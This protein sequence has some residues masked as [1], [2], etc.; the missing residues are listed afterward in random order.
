VWRPARKREMEGEGRSG[1]L[2]AM[3]QQSGVRSFHN[4]RRNLSGPGEE[5]AKVG[6]GKSAKKTAEEAEMADEAE[7]YAKYT[8]DWKSASSS[9]RR[10]FHDESEKQTLMFI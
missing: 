5:S 7:I 6:S 4:D 9:P 2:M 10:F 1:K 8:R 3:A